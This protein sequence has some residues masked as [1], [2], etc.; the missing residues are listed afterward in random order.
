MGMI[1]RNKW[2]ILLCILAILIL[3]IVVSAWQGGQRDIMG[4]RLGQRVSDIEGL[5]LKTTLP[6]KQALYERMFPGDSLGLEGNFKTI[7]H[8]R[9]DSLIKIMIKV[10]KDSEAEGLSEANAA[11]AALK[12]RFGSPTKKEIYRTSP[13][14]GRERWFYDWWRPYAIISL[15][16]WGNTN[17]VYVF[18]KSV[19]A[20]VRDAIELG[21]IGFR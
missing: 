5:S 2:K 10:K 7:Y 15:H 16:Y 20:S 13:S 9:E 1:I 8:F 14:E 12:S 19:W 18:Y 11:L 6:E 4:A 21:Q 3:M 17:E